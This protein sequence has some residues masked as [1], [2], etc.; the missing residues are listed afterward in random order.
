MQ[1]PSSKSRSHQVCW[2]RRDL[3][4]H[5]HAALSAATKSDLTTICIFVFDKSILDE[6]KN[7]K[8]HHVQFM[9]DSLVELD[10]RLKKINQ[11]LV[12]LYG[13][14]VE[15]IPQFCVKN[16][17]HKVF[18]NRDYEP[19]ALKRDLQVEKNL[20]KFKIEFESFKD[21]VIFEPQE[22]LKNN[23]EPYRVFTP[24]KNAWLKKLVEHK[25]SPKLDN[26]LTDQ[27]VRA[28]QIS[29][30]HKYE[31]LENYPIK[32]LGFEQVELNDFKTGTSGAKYHLDSFE[33]SEYKNER[34]TPGRE[35]TSRLSPHL[36][37]GTL[38]IRQCTHRALKSRD[39]GHTTWLNELI[40]R[41]FYQMILF[42]FPHAAHESFQPQYKDL[43]WPGEKSHLKLW[44]RGET[45]FPIV[46]AG[47]RQLSETGWMH[48]R[49]RMIVASFLTKDLLINWQEGEDWF[50]E[51]LIDY[52]LASNNGGWQW[53]AS[54]GCDAQPYF[55]VFNPAL[56]SEKFDPDGDYIK[57][58]VPELR[59]L[60]SKQIHE[61]WS[62]E[63]S[64]PLNA[65]AANALKN[66]PQP[67]VD[68]QTQKLRAIKLFK[69]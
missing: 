13:D 65:K 62:D 46:D 43:R 10:D 21:H 18:Y 40:W 12:I 50:R 69:K 28:K 66:Y 23:G 64:N 27:P 60:S 7:K 37:F 9:Y 67:I 1:S 30:P 4:L 58:Y 68:H 39:L 17:I 54:T 52:E 48:N 42:H 44:Q 3:R 26:P 22:V 20:S 47:M 63:N 16:N 57:K 41:E 56:Q 34:D 33:I 29:L 45:G 61:P 55:R 14:P 38:S 8:S 35:G 51:H 2:I 15:E 59:D 53:A 19:Y 24:Y 49:V 31:T 36:R 6:I 25:G 11:R 5:D 32:K